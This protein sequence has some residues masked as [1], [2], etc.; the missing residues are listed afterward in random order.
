MNGVAVT[1]N[2]DSCN[3]I[4][5]F[6]FFSLCSWQ[7][8]LTPLGLFFLAAVPLRPGGS[9]RSVATKTN[10]VSTGTL[11]LMTPRRQLLCLRHTQS[12]ACGRPAWNAET[13]DVSY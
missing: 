11:S 9:R 7:R 2:L 1:H 10:V 4:Q 5:S 6:F 13:P 12:T 3:K 8:L